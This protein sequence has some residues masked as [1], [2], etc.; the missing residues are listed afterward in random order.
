MDQSV[1]AAIAKWPN[2]PAVYGWLAL[3]ARGEWRLKGEPIANVAIRDFI[4]R[5]Y[6]C[7]E[8]GRWYFQ[9]GPQRVFVE[10]E[11]APWVWR[12]DSS[13]QGLL[14]HTGVAARQLFG[15]WLDDQ[16]RAFLRTDLGFGLVDPADTARVGEAFRTAD[17]R[18]PDDG[19]LESWLN[20]AGPRIRVDGARLGLSGDCELEQLR[21][22]EA[23][24]RFGYVRRPQVN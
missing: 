8:R 11:V 7:D 6:A 1:I 3:T 14:T 23:P 10:L 19:E 4:G 17:Q 21:A 9:N 20:A 16:G 13:G 24:Q 22:A 2:V 15:A 18:V 5:N 12:V